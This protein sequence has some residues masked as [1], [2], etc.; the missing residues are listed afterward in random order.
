[1]TQA[2]QAEQRALRSVA[3]A[4]IACIIARGLEVAAE[5]AEAEAVLADR[6]RAILG[7]DKIRVNCGALKLPARIV[8][9]MAGQIM[10]GGDNWTA[11]HQRLLDDAETA[12]PSRIEAAPEKEQSRLQR[13]QIGGVRRL[14]GG[15]TDGPL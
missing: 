14:D 1:M 3:E 13:S 5:I 9:A 12:L 2:V 6:R 4:A 10:H 15:T 11:A 7:I 8:S